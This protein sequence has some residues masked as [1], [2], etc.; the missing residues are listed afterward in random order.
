V[1]GWKPIMTSALCVD[2]AQILERYTV[3]KHASSV[4]A[5]VLLLATVA[6]ASAQTNGDWILANYRGAGYWFPGIVESIRGGQIT[7]LYDDGEREIVSRGNVRPY[8]WMIG[9]KVECNFKGL[10]DWYQGTIASLAGET[11]GIAYDD[12]DKETT[13]TGRCRSS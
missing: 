8:D 12:G 9:M 10:G 6:T 13:K 7:V 1:A 2:I 5:A 4:I 11:I 3:F